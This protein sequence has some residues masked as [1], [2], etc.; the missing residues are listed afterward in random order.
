MKFGE[1]MLS[2]SKIMIGFMHA[3]RILSNIG[4]ENIF[5]V[6]D[7]HDKNVKVLSLNSVIQD[8]I[9]HRCTY[10]FSEDVLEK[11]D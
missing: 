10:T 4:D 1:V 3:K 7:K 2:K 9:S 6:I 8:G 11:M 5:K